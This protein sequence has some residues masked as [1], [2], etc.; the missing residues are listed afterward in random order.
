MSAGA[1]DAGKSLASQAPDPASV[2]FEGR[3][4]AVRAGIVRDAEAEPARALGDRRDPRRGRG[5]T[6]R[7]RAGR[8]A[9]PVAAARRDA[10]GADADGDDDLGD[11]AL[12]RAA[13]ATRDRVVRRY[14][15]GATVHGIDGPGDED[16]TT[17]GE[18]TIQSPAD[19]CSAA[20]RNGAEPPAA[21]ASGAALPLAGAVAGI[22]AAVLA[23][24]LV[25]QSLGSVF[26]FW[27]HEDEARRSVEGLPPYVTYSMVLAALECQDEY[28]HPAGC[29]LAQVIV[30]SGVGDHLS[31][32]A[33]RDN[34]LFGIKWASS[35]A[36]CPEVTGKESWQTSEEYGGASVTVAAAFTRFRSAEDCIRFRSRVLLQAA[37]YRDN[38]KIRQAMATHDS[39][40][41]AEGLKEAGY[42]TSSSYVDSLKSAMDAYGLRRFDSMTAADLKAAGTAGTGGG[43]IVAAAQTQIGTPY[44]WGGTTPYRALDCSG[45]TQWCYAQAGIR[46]PRNSEDQAA[47]GTRVPLSQAQ[48]G[49]ILWKPGHVG[50]YIG[51][52]SYI[53]APKPGD[54]VRVGTG[55]G[56]FTC[57]IRY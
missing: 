34:N 55:I 40:L 28:G 7:R 12:R 14:Q 53:H 52:D 9:G 45:L 46:I 38:A 3:T 47:A 37:N 8:A 32:L 21:A 19:S 51:G 1:R 48:P 43:A 11:D 2:A 44:V 6:A 50:I 13:R 5:A 31:G 15:E 49:D 39:D 18:T 23:A 35:F 10:F 20:P 27:E 56:Y 30:E 17:A 22:L 4:D 41:M 29:T 25:S 33:T 57:A 16:A 26:G 36:S 24:T 42:A 54:H